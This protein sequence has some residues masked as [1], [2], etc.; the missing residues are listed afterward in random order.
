MLPTEHQ[1]VLRRIRA[2]QPLI[3]KGTAGAARLT[4]TVLYLW[5]RKSFPDLIYRSPRPDKRLL[6]KPEVI[7]FAGWLAKCDF[8]NAAFWLS[9]AYAIWVG[10]EQRMQR[11]MYFTPPYFS[12]RLIDNLLAN[13]ANLTRHVWMDPACGGA[14]FL[15]PIAYRMAQQLRA[16][17]LKPKAI[18]DHIANHLIGNDVDPDLARLSKQ[19][20]RMSLHKEIVEAGFEP[21]F[22]ISKVDALSSLKRQQGKVDVVICNPPYRKMVASEVSRYRRNYKDVIVGQPNLYA[23]FFKL[24]LDFLKQDGVGGLLTPTSFLSGQYFSPLRTYLLEN[25]ETLQL[26][27][28]QE[29]VGVFVAA[30]LDTAI[31]ILRKR[32]L[33]ETSSK[34]TRVFVFHRGNGFTDV[35]RC[36]LP[37][38][39]TSWP[40]PRNEDDARIM[41]SING[42]TFRLSHYGYQARTG[43][44][45]WNRDKRK[46]FYSEKAALK[47]GAPFPLIWSSAV[48]QNGRFD[49]GRLQDMDGRHLYV[50]MKHKD[51]GSVVRRP[52]VA[53]QRVTSPDQPRRLVGA[54]VSKL[55]MKKFGGVV[56]EN[57]VVFLEQVDSK[58]KF[59]PSKLAAV[60]RSDLID[61]L[62]RC[63]SGVVNVS[64]FELNQ[65]PLPDPVRLHKELAR[66]K[67]VNEA[68]IRAFTLKKHR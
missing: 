45:V 34:K 52:C 61:R 27:I 66:T 14:A 41:R 53:L 39:G 55:L 18:L 23:L 25:A 15:A 36:K 63:I 6:R 57:H 24:S 35:G 32:E 64:I 42:S 33:K 10:E 7:A 19:F 16:R 58:P 1:H 13:K 65:L 17:D 11:A 59:A 62:F 60:L 22:K 68:V 28:V 30:E 21:K 40:I 5:Q 47:S 51:H 48:S 44:F 37:N 54:P 38:S 56:G 46:T 29:R 12:A 26:D 50:N 31:T 3:K 67:D 49:F 43:A 4:F 20:L 8:L 2:L 9:S